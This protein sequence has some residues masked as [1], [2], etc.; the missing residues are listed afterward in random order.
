M[1]KQGFAKVLTVMELSA[2]VAG[3]AIS[4]YV[5]N[6]IFQNTI[7]PSNSILGNSPSSSTT[8]VFPP[9]SRFHG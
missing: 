7:P 2:D 5:A 9:N 3:M 1:K 4:F 8:T 6:A